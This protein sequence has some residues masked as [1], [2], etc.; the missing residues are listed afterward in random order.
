MGSDERRMFIHRAVWAIVP[1]IIAGSF[2][3]G[4]AWATIKGE[5]R[6]VRDN[7]EELRD[8]VDHNTGQLIDH[9]VYEHEQITLEKYHAK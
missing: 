9:R 7:V 8:D 3:A 5:I 1:G 2:T 6:H 4:I